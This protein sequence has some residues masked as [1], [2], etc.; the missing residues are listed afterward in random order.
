MSQ[1]N[2]PQD[3]Y[4][5]VSTS[6]QGYIVLPHIYPMWESATATAQLVANTVYGLQVMI[7][8]QITISKFFV[9]A[10]AS[11]FLSFTNGGSVAA[12]SGGHT[13]YSR[14]FGTTLGNNALGGTFTLSAAATASGGNTVYTG[15]GFSGEQNLTVTI[16]GFVTGANNGTF[17]I[18]SSTGT[19]ITV[20]NPSG[21]AET[22][23]GTATVAS[24]TVLASGFTNAAN[25]GT[26]TVFS[27]GSNSITLNNASGVVE[28][29]T[30]GKISVIPSASTHAGMGLYDL[31]GNL[32][33]SGTISGALGL[34]SATVSPVTIKPGTYY[35]CWT[36]DTTTTIQVPDSS[37]HLNGGQ[38]A[39]PYGQMMPSIP[40]GKYMFTAANVGVAGVL[41]ST[42]GVLTP[43]QAN[44]PTCVCAP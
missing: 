28:S 16:A 4:L 22:H 5:T 34:R 35:Y 20:N 25:N 27:N 21:V 13:V 8:F 11:Y 40:T 17:K 19:T 29:P 31:N 18:I 7:P 39:G 10:V 33:V 32:L 6:G 43:L 36:A 24:L 23:A 9:N 42:L 37:L 44:F 26:F 14:T 2:N 12:A 41:P 30:S 15:S 3:G 1:I 38:I